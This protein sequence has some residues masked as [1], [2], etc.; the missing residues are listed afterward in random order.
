MNKRF[1]IAFAKPGTESLKRFR[2]VEAADMQAAIYTA[3]LALRPGAFTRYTRRTRETMA[4]VAPFE[5]E[6]HPNG[7]PIVV[8]GFSLSF[9]KKEAA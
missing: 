2:T 6:R 9:E 1:L 3:L 7:A 8:H 4:Y 5:V